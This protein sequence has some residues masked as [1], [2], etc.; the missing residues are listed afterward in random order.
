M[1]ASPPS[2]PS[3]MAKEV[4]SPKS[5]KTMNLHTPCQSSP[6]SSPIKKVSVPFAESPKK[7]FSSTAS[8]SFVTS[9]S[10]DFLSQINEIIK[11]IRSESSAATYENSTIKDEAW[12]VAEMYK[13]MSERLQKE[14]DELLKIL[15]EQAD[16]FYVMQD[17]ISQLQGQIA[18]LALVSPSSSKQQQPVENHQQ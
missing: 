2:A 11:S 5:P 14:K 8:D 17:Y 16:Q 7:M 1:T 10:S 12:E 13:K 6:K 9:S 4:H 15:A 3:T 18:A